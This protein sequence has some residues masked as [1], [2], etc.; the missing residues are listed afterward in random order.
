MTSNRPSMSVPP[1][2]EKKEAGMG[3]FRPLDRRLLTP[4]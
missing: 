2:N 4:P 3:L 1:K